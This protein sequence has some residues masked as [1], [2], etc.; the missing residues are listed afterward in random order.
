[1]QTLEE[2]KTRI[3][4]AVP[5][6]RVE[7]VPNTAVPA[8]SSLRIDN[9]HAL[10]AA[11]F[12]RDDNLM[13]FDYASNATGVDWPARVLKEKIKVKKN[14]GGVEKEVEEAVERRTEPYLE[15]VYHLYSMTLKHGPLVLRLRTEAA[16]AMS[17]FP[18]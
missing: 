18:R 10:A 5:G 8:Q 3:E 13:R 1:M 16:P 15:A 11:R 7:T 14:V 6:A 9:E 4:S 12:L 17:S 2:I